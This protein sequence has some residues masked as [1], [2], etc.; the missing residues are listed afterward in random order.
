MQLLLRHVNYVWTNI[1]WKLVCVNSI[2]HSVTVKTTLHWLLENVINVKLELNSL[3]RPLIVILLTKFPTVFS[4]LISTHVPNVTFFTIERKINAF[5]FPLKPTVSTWRMIFVKNV[6]MDCILKIIN[7]NSPW[8]L[9]NWIVFW[10]EVLFLNIKSV[11]V[12]MRD[13]FHMISKTTISVLLLMKTSNP[14]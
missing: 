13:S 9:N 6:K 12:V 14:M 4:T 8:E 11:K 3:L 7:V 5:W 1:T 2:L 10:K